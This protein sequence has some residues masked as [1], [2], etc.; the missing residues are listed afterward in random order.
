MLA[1][2]LSDRMKIARAVIEDIPQ[3]VVVTILGRLKS[4]YVEPEERLS[5]TIACIFG[6]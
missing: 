1:C 2:V 5:L 6:V 3:M 4:V